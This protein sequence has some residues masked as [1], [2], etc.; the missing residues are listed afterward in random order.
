MDTRPANTNVELT[1]GNDVR[2]V[3]QPTAGG[4]VEL[5]RIGDTWNSTAT[6]ID[7]RLQSDIGA[8]LNEDADGRYYIYYGNAAAGTPPTNEM[9]VYYFADFFTRANSSTVGNGWTEWNDGTSNMYIQGNVLYP[10]GNNVGPPDAG[11]KQSLGLGAITGNFTLSF[12]VTIQTNAEGT[13]THYVNVG[14]SAT[15]LNSSRTTGVGPG[16][17]FGEGTHFVPDSGNYNISNDLSG[18]METG[19]TGA[20]KYQSGGEYG[21]KHL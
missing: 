8:N 16:I 15:M 7:F 21:G 4:A 6:N 14:N 10:L 17:Y 11:V 5:A 2:V 18:N 1:S 20:R 13:W 12:N 19:V 3:W 9:N